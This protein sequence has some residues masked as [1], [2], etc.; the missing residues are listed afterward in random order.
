MKTLDKR[1]LQETLDYIDECIQHGGK[2]ESLSKLIIAADVIEEL[3]VV[4][5]VFA[6]R[7]AKVHDFSFFMPSGTDKPDFSDVSVID[8]GQTLRLGTYEVGSDSLRD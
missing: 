6:D 7:V 4:V 8:N 2:P 5:T 3:E 1:Q